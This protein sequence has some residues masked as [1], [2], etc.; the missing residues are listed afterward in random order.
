MFSFWTCS[1]NNGISG[2]IPSSLANIRN[3]DT[4]VLNGNRLTGAI[5]SQLGAVK[6]VLLELANN[7]LESVPSEIGLLT[8]LQ[9]LK[10]VSV[11]VPDTPISTRIWHLFYFAKLT[12]VTRP[13]LF[14]VGKQSYQH[15][16]PDGTRQFGKFDCV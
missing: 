3:L 5:P 11:V 7:L 8:E 1:A 15:C 9:S 12:H 14:C 10:L 6:L 4:I 13:F 2:S 16:D